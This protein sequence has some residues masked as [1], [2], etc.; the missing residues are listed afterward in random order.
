MKKKYSSPEI[1]V[2]EFDEPVLLVGSDCPDV[3]CAGEIP[4]PICNDEDPSEGSP[5]S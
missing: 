4:N 3:I 1:E 2:L 5:N